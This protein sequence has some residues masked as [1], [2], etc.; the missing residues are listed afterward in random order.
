MII[1]QEQ[2][3]KIELFTKLR[4]VYKLASDDRRK[5]ILNILIDKIVVSNDYSYKIKVYLNY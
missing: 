1:N 3:N 4:D 2:N 5:Q